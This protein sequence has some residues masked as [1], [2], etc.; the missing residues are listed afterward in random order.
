MVTETV[1]QKMITFAVGQNPVDYY[2]DNHPYVYSFTMDSWQTRHAAPELACNL[3]AGK[4]PGEF[5]A[6][7]D[8][9][10]DYTKP[11]K[12][13]LILYQDEIRTGAR[14]QYEK[15]FAKCGGKFDLVQEYNI[16]D[17][18]QAIAGTAAKMKQAGVTTI[19]F[20]VDPLTPAVVVAEAERIQYFPEY[21]GVTGLDSNGT[22]RLMND[23]Q[24]EHFVTMRAFEMPRAH[25]DKD[26]FRAYK[27]VD[28]DGDPPSGTYGPGLYRAVQQFSGG[29]QLA[30]TKLTPETFWKGLKQTPCRTPDPVWSIGGCYK[31][32]DPT[33]AVHFLGD[34][35][36]SDYIMLSWFDLKGDDPESTETGAYCFMH[37]GRRYR[38]GEFPKEPLP[39]KDPKQCIITPARGQQG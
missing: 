6:K 34:Y 36:Y 31:D 10:F 37:G 13:G 23:N 38:V 35:T 3:W 30:G 27:E 12:W 25:E 26:W 9:T 19:M 5:N 15:E 11:R 4:P 17:N 29:V 7:Q 16:T 24:S 2:A 32:P 28:P 39:F 1:K 14:Q 22:G 8:L 33:S 18:Q 20:A 21:I